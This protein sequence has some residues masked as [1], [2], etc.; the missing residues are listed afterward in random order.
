MELVQNQAQWPDLIRLVAV[1]YLLVVGLLQRLGWQVRP[2]SGL[3]AVCVA[4]VSYYNGIPKVLG[5]LNI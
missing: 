1:L 4:A 5:L 2:C 3:H